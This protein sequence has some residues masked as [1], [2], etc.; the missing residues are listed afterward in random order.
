[1]S[2]ERKVNLGCM[3]LMFVFAALAILFTGGYFINGQ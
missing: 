1:M 3:V 2:L